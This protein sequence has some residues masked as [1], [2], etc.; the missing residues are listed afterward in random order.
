MYETL[1]GRA[2]FQGNSPLEIIRMHVDEMAAPLEVANCAPGLVKSLDR[3][4]FKAM[5]KDPARR[6]QSMSALKKDLLEASE[7]SE[8]STHAG[9]GYIG[10]ARL[11]RQF[12]KTI[13]RHP[14]KFAGVVASVVALTCFALYAYSLVV[15]LTELPKTIA[16]HD[17]VWDQPDVKPRPPTYG[18]TAR[19]AIFLFQESQNRSNVNL[20]KTLQG[21]KLLSGFF[22]QHGDWAQAR[23][24]LKEMV[25]ILEN[26]PD[27]GPTSMDAIDANQS[28]GLCLYRLKEYSEAARSFSTAI[29]R[30]EEARK[31]QGQIVG[32]LFS[33]MLDVRYANTLRLTG[34]ISTASFW[35]KRALSELYSLRRGGRGVSDLK[36][37]DA[38]MVSAAALSPRASIE[39][40]LLDAMARAGLADC[41]VL[42]AQRNNSELDFTRAVAEYEAA[43]A[44]WKSVSTSNPDIAQNVENAQVGI[45]N[46]AILGKNYKMA[47]AEIDELLSTPGGRK[48]LED[49]LFRQNYARVLWSAGDYVK[50]VRIAI[51][52]KLL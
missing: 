16:S 39:E 6:Y 45:V 5:E 12:S 2:P 7:A 31:I 46:A 47:A 28:Y 3:I 4:I 43:Q 9:A 48:V 19:K 13:V 18:N 52:S 34:E 42:F 23:D 30:L 49:P 41:D 36:P 29:S 15:P 51:A 20:K 21:H 22:F 1:V 44:L 33:P 26:D 25:I 32:N 11:L 17:W 10:I 38:T 40:R 14:I 8:L 50:A 35:Y 24:H 27:Y 37:V